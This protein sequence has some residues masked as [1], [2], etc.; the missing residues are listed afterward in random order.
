MNKTSITVLEDDTL[1]RQGIEKMIGDTPDLRC[2]AS[3]NTV[4]SLYENLNG[5]QSNVFWLD[6]NLPDGSGVEV[7][8]N[9]LKQKPE[10]L[11]L[12]CS[13]YDDDKHVFEAMKAGASAYLL[14]TTNV[15]RMLESIYELI[16][17]GSPMS[18]FIARK[19][20]KTFR[21][22][23]V[24]KEQVTE[25]LTQRET[26]VLELIAKGLLYKEVAEKL[27]ISPETVKK[28]LRNTYVKL[29]VQNRTEAVIKYM[30]K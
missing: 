8:K 23:E 10:A 9:I 17:G 11:C 27:D 7:I 24:A 2:E 12:V 5:L 28:H 3:Y 16:D 1:F 18:P 22:E 21:A 15:D 6:I 4:Q 19:L 20:I 25:S 30:G 13:L 26:E 14:K 29:Q